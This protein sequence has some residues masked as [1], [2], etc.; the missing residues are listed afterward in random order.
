MHR[1]TKI[2]SSAAAV[3]ALSSG[4]MLAATP[5]MAAVTG[6]YTTDFAQESINTTVGAS[7]ND[8]R[9]TGGYDATITQGADPA[10]R[11]SNAV[12][13]GSFGDQLFSPTLDTPAT[14]TGPARTFTASFVLEPVQLQPG[15]RVTVSPDNGQGGRGGFLAIEHTN[16]GI[17][18]V[19]QG[20]YFD[21]EGN[22]QWDVK[23]VATGLDVSKPHTVNLKLAK[24]PY[25]KKS[26]STNNDV[27]S[28]QVDGKPIKN[29]T[30]EAYY[31]ATGEDNYQTDTLMFRLSGT[32]QSQVAAQGLLIDNV[33][34]ATS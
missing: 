18:L 29:T 7:D 20:S 8:W 14:E 27:F 33:T 3:V 22:L 25:T 23:T 1:T 24:K 12:T 10:L 21:E 16:A 13:S 30:F 31:D 28:V 9:M 5:A 26:P 19:S 17:N 6:P 15:L 4:L 2:A 34:I 32:A 11:I